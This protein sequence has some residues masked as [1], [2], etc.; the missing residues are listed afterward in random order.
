MKYAQGLRQI[1]DTF[2][3]TGAKKAFNDFSG[4]CVTSDSSKERN[5]KVR[6]SKVRSSEPLRM[7]LSMSNFGTNWAASIVIEKVLSFQSD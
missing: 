3:E 2:I 1:V 7:H 6:H 5:S 4:V